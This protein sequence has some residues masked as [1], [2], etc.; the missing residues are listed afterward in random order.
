MYDINVPMLFDICFGLKKDKKNNFSACKNIGAAR[1][2]GYIAAFQARLK[3]SQ[4]AE[5]WN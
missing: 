3:R 5:E 1:V 2:C 4:Q